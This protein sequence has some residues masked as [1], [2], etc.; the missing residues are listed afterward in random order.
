[1]LLMGSQNVATLYH[2]V[3]SFFICSWSNLLAR[4]SCRQRKN[5]FYQRVWHQLANLGIF[6]YCGYF[7][8]RYDALWL[9]G[10]FQTKRNLGT[11]PLDTDADCAVY[12]TADT[13]PAK[14][15]DICD[16]TIWFCNRVGYLFIYRRCGYPTRYLTLG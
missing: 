10:F 3:D 11:V 9:S 6:N 15:S 2:F 12:R 16:F 1:M 8:G 13:W 14:N 5:S 4:R 7:Y